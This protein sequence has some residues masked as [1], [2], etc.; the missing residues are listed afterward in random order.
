MTARA[1]KDINQLST[2]LSDRPSLSTLSTRLGALLQAPVDTA[3]L[4]YFRIIFGVVVAWEGRRFLA[5]ARAERYLDKNILFTFWPFDFL[6]DLPRQ[7]VTGS[8]YLMMF[9]GIMFALGY[10]YRASAIAVFVTLTYQ[11]LLDKSYYLNHMYLMCLLAFLMIFLPANREWSMD[12]RLDPGLRQSKTPAWTLWIMRLQ[13][14]IPY[15]YAGVAKLINKDWVYRSE[16]LGTWL[17]QRMDLPV[18]GQYFDQEAVVRAMSLGA[19]VLDI[20][21]VFLLLNKRT[22]VFAYGAALSFHLLNSGLFEIG[23]FPWM[24]IGATAIFFPADWPRTFLNDF[25][26]HSNLPRLGASVVGAVVIGA[27]ASVLPARTFSPMHLLFGALG[28]AI[29]GYHLWLTFRPLPTAAP[30]AVKAENSDQPASDGPEGKSTPA[31]PGRMRRNVAFALTV[32]VA[33]QLLIPLRHFAIPGDV[34]WT[35]EGHAFS[36]RMLLRDKG[37]EIVFFVKDP[38]TGEN[39]RVE[40]REFLTAQQAESLIFTPTMILHFAHYLRDRG[41]NSGRKNI[42][43]RANAMVSLNGRKR[44]PLIDP[45]VNLAAVTRPWFGHADWITTTYPPVSAGLDPE[46]TQ[47]QPKGPKQGNE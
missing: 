6:A 23:V 11:F 3:G 27:I 33:L 8:F 4:A 14:G 36:W 13:V 38:D 46:N 44:A 26:T 16:P 12:A 25:R 21:V 37:G 29:L 15:F 10:Y 2:K 39:W 1:D 31:A 42:E 7:V 40:P 17:R 5:G 19:L 34:T 24:M 35:E 43:V 22:R 28:G 45:T 20:S 32:W 9:S 18:L 30:V 47:S 41:V